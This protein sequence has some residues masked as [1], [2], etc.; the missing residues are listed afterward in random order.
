MT[1][2]M[3]VLMPQLGETVA[4]GK[5]TKWFKSAGEPVKPGDNLFEIETDKVS[6][7]VPS[8]TTGVL[9]EIRVAAGDVAPVGAVVAVIADGAAAQP[10]QPAAASSP[11]RRLANQPRAFAAPA[12]VSIRSCAATADEPA[13]SSSIRSS[14]CAR[15]RAT[16]ARRGCPAAPRSRRWRAGSPPNPAST[17]RA[18]KAPVRTAASSR[19]DIENAPRRRDATL[20]RYRRPERRRDQ[21]ALRRRQ[22]TKKCRSTACAAPLRRG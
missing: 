18:P 19:S 16:S 2:L 7:E 10:S 22:L 17:F 13:R 4:E 9:S 11:R 3:D 20:A 5:I 6:M 14:K 1:R 21:G 12:A 15:R 8:T